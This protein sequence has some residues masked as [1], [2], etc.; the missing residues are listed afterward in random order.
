MS[1]ALAAAHR[2][3]PRGLCPALTRQLVLSISNFTGI[4]YER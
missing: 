1:A 2:L 4:L 3:P